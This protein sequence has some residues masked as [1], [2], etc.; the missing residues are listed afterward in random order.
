MQRK[1][2]LDQIRSISPCREFIKKRKKNK[3]R[4]QAK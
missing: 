1:T 4:V 3:R 2:A